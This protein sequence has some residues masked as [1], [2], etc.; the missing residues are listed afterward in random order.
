VNPNS[1]STLIAAAIVG[2]VLA[3][4]LAQIVIWTAT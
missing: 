2:V 4:L 1:T 3:V